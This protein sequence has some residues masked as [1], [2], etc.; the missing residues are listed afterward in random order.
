MPDELKPVNSP[1]TIDAMQPAK[2]VDAAHALQRLA[3]ALLMGAQFVVPLFLNQDLWRDSL[4][5]SQVSLGIFVAVLG[6]L[7]GR[8]LLLLGP[9]IAVLSFEWWSV[10]PFYMQPYLTQFLLAHSVCHVLVFGVARLRGVQGT[11]S[12]GTSSD[13]QQAPPLQISIKSLLMVTTMVASTLALANW[14]REAIQGEPY[15]TEDT[16][17]Y[18]IIAAFDG[19][20]TSLLTLSIVWAL[21]TQGSPLKFGLSLIFAVSLGAIQIFAFRME[22]FWHLAAYQY[23]AWLILT[24][25]SI[26]V[27][28]L[29][30]WSL[31]HSASPFALRGT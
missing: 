13:T 8:A 26:L 27:M 16:T 19:F 24:A 1:L 3:L 18:L 5:L 25:G 14:L 20:G 10:L 15:F 17:K 28:K 29:A 6:G 9:L 7:S 11:W 23:A 22:E 4:L 30:G 21:G 12:S 2:S 31:T